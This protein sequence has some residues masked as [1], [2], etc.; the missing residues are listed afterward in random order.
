MH[1]ASH[2]G[3]VHSILT[4]SA[5]EQRSIPSSRSCRRD[6]DTVTITLADPT[7]HV[8]DSQATPKQDSHQPTLQT[9]ATDTFSDP[10]LAR[11]TL[12]TKFRLSSR[13]SCRR[14]LS[15][16]NE[17]RCPQCL[18]LPSL[19]HRPQLHLRH[20]QSPRCRETRHARPGALRLQLSDHYFDY[21]GYQSFHGP[22]H[23]NI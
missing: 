15:P 4:F 2:S 14:S 8:H 20:I 22:F 3:Q 17:E 7:K 13:R 23:C 21:A 10:P 16:P 5:H 19:L 12:N 9:L 6:L 18:A 11:P 1:H